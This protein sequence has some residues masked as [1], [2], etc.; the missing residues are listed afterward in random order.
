MRVVG[1]AT[2]LRQT[3]NLLSY[4]LDTR[5]LSDVRVMKEKDRV[6]SR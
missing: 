1:P 6:K 4:L 2:E 5:V 3:Q